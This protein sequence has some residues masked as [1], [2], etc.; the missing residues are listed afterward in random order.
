MNAN[1]PAQTARPNVRLRLVK[2]T[3]KNLAIKSGVKA[4]VGG[5]R[6]G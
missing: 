6:T 5:S 4:G 2:Q 1:V 3:V